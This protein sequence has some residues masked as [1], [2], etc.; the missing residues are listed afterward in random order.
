M[1][2]KSLRDLLAIVEDEVSLLTLFRGKKRIFCPSLDIRI[3][4]KDVLVLEGNPEA[5]KKLLDTHPIRLIS[6]KE[7]I[8]EEL[9]SEDVK[10]IEAIIPPDSPLT[11]TTGRSFYSRF[12][13]I[14]L[15]ISRSGQCFIDRLSRLKFQSGD[16]LLLQGTEKGLRNAL[17][18]TKCLPLAERD[19]LPVKGKVSFWPLII[20]AGAIILTFLEIIPASLAFLLAVIAMLLFRVISTTEAYQAVD[21]SVII[22]IGALLPFGEALR[23]TGT[24][25]LIADTLLLETQ[26][27]DYLIISLLL[28]ISMLLSD[29]INNAATA[30]IMAPI[31]V[32]IAN[33]IGASIDPFL[34]TVAIGS[35]CTFLTPI[36]HPSNTLVMGPGCYKF[37]DYWRMGLPLDIII[38]I[39]AVPLILWVWPLWSQ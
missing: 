20:F 5:L 33:S 12:D 9:Y 23:T 2:G 24:T 21:F 25:T 32:E 7:H 35:S 28:V 8:A 26:L 36:G 14:L 10:M 38:I 15:A 39:L 16:V 19:L 31:A 22:L 34:I 30:V 1:I 11:G 27:S 37:R 4:P 3:Y 29:V 18:T 13:A 17:A 6:P